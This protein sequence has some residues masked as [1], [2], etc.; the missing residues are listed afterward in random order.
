MA[1]P[2]AQDSPDGGW[3]AP[4]P[5]ADDAVYRVVGTENRTPT[6]RE[7]WLR[8]LTSGLTYRPGEYV[9]LEDRDAG[10]PP[11]SYSIANA[12][13]P[14]GLISLLVTRVPS[15]ATSPW[16]HDHVRVGDDL[17][18][19]GPYG[20]FVD[21]VA[22]RTPCLLLAAGSG[23]APER[24]LV[25]AALSVRTRSSVTLVFSV[26]TAADA[27]DHKRFTRAQQT[28]PQF[29]FACTTTRETGPGLHGR[30]PTVLPDICADLVDH[31]VFIAGAPGFVEACA[32]TVSALGA[33][34]P[35]VHTEAFF[36]EPGGGSRQ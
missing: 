30:V 9:L 33:R 6:I 20:T 32:D 1:E 10:T 27:M 11:R 15:G 31:D 14:D 25:E 19:S 12:P 23:L 16:I 28:H 24:A 17:S 13:R 18:I 34:P 2:R 29:R 26:R 22:A 21:D 3:R 5:Q 36:A 7:L 4:V 35:R 8:P